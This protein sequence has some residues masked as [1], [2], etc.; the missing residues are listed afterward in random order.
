MAMVMRRLGQRI[1]PIA[2]FHSTSATAA[3]SAATRASAPRVVDQIVKITVIDEDGHRLP[4]NGFVGQSLF[5]ALTRS[6][7]R[8]PRSHLLEYV[9]ACSGETCQVSIANE[10]LQ[11]MPPRTEDEL[12]VL[13]RASGKEKVDVH[14]RLGCQVVLTHD[15]DGM[16][17]ALG[18]EKA[19]Y[20]L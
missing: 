4:V 18:Q 15:L 19:W 5:K 16:V 3:V 10:W 12:D 13:V 11:K 9:S 8:D 2:R 1:A 7:L 6:G 20:Y 14:T 17:V